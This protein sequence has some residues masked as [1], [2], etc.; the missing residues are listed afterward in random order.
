M[1]FE[2]QPSVTA[3]AVLAL[4]FAFAFHL[5]T[6]YVAFLLVR[7]AYAGIA[8]E[9]KIPR[10]L[11][12]VCVVGAALLIYASLPRRVR[13]VPPGPEL[14]PADQPAIW[15]MIRSLAHDTGQT[16]PTAAYWDPEPN[17]SVTSIGGFLGLGGR[18][19]MTLGFPLAVSLDADA[20]RAV[21]AHEFGHY[22]AGDVT[23][24][25][26][27][28]VTQS[29]VLRATTSLRVAAKALPLLH[30]LNLPF[31]GF[32][33]L[34]LRITRAVSRRQEFSA[35]AL[36]ARLV[37]SG[38]M[39]R[40][41]F[42]SGRFDRAWGEYMEAD[43]APLLAAERRP[44]ITSGWQTYLNSPEVR[45]ALADT[46]EREGERTTGRRTSA[47][48]Y[49]THPSNLDRLRALGFVDGSIPESVGTSNR[50][51]AVAVENVDSLELDLLEA[52]TES[53]AIRGY[54]TIAWDRVIPEFSEPRW[55]ELLTRHSAGIRGTF[56]ERLPARA[57]DLTE[58]G[59]M[60]NPRDARD[61]AGDDQCAASVLTAALAV[62][63]RR[64]GFAL[65]SRPGTPLRAQRGDEIV[66]VEDVVRG[67]AAGRVSATAW[68]D[69]CCA[70]G[71]A[72]LDL[73]AEAAA[74][75]E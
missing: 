12:A 16:V 34:Y 2:R 23:L 45:D 9:A 28:Y 10:M 5:M 13:F 63:L 68:A 29:G 6:G 31:L 65:E 25:P 32:S 61:P 17:A 42:E 18:R 39:G 11:I 8:G 51:S 44:P 49:D 21:L 41:L 53:P 38:A 26:L 36:A 1:S 37:S 46:E 24:G 66:N 56:A 14:R 48:P 74:Y 64:R 52:M 75:L 33:A 27:V 35:D 43:V 22:H 59:R 30:L 54:P 67:L 20:L 62:S 72:G 58:F 50:P 40:A 71:I 15:E 7:I 60:L 69:R 73:G 70:L 47:G 3:R 19:V 55:R 57:E 4:A